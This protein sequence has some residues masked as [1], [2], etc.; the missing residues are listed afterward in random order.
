M[1]RPP[2]WH[3]TSVFFPLSSS[4]LV[5]VGLVWLFECVVGD[6]SVFG[7]GG[8]CG[9]REVG[10]TGDR[11]QT[12]THTTPQQSK[13][14]PV[15]N[16]GPPLRELREGQVHEA[17]AGDVR[18]RDLVRLAHVDELVLWLCF[19][20]FVFGVWWYLDDGVGL[21]ISAYLRTSEGIRSYT[22][23]PSRVHESNPS[24]LV[25]LPR[26]SRMGWPA[27]PAAAAGACPRARGP[28]RPPVIGLLFY[29]V[30]VCEKGFGC[31]FGGGRRLG[32]G[33]HTNIYMTHIHKCN[34]PQPLP[35]YVCNEQ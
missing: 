4:S 13:H 34:G 20:C 11:K 29:G 8:G 26:P 35:P 31:G 18:R 30:C 33:W 7:E 9:F 1:E 3:S 2:W 22:H 15:Q 12:I 24:L 23:T 25:C 17:A 19:C 32:E 14:P 21:R 16:L 27:A 28:W 5:V 10:W 6:V